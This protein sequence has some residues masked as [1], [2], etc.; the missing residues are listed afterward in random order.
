[1]SHNVIGLCEANIAM[2]SKQEKNM[3]IIESL[4]SKVKFHID[5]VVRRSEPLESV[6]RCGMCGK[7]KDN[8]GHN[9]CEDCAGV[10]F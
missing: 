9:C 4:K 8:D 7:I 5:H 3:G 6:S 2:T 10:A 1:M